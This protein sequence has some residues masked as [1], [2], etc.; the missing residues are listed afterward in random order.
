MTGSRG[1]RL[2]LTCL[3]AY[4]CSMIAARNI[5]VVMKVSWARLT[6]DV[7]LP[8][9][10]GLGFGANGSLLLA[11]MK[12]SSCDPTRPV[13]SI[14]SVIR[15]CLHANIILSITKRRHLV[16]VKQQHSVQLSLIQQLLTPSFSNRMC[17]SRWTR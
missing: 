12:D 8:T 4:S 17:R 15:L 1:R 5:P 13:S 11:R 16:V 14:P 2:L 7:S 9:A 6:D 3:L 10:V